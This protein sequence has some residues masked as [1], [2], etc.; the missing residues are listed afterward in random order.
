MFQNCYP[1]YAKKCANMASFSNMAN[2]RI[3]IFGGN[4]AIRQ[5]RGP[6]F[7]NMT[8]AF[9]NSSQKTT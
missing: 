8:I 7:L 9:L 3:C 5:I 1:K 4:F 6:W 2:L